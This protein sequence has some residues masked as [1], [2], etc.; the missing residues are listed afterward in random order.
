MKQITLEKNPETG[1][2][3]FTKESTLKKIQYGFMFVSQ[4]LLDKKA[5]EASFSPQ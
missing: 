5:N 3:A 4:V 2:A 1:K